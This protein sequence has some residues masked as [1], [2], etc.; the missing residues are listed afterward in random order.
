MSLQKLSDHETFVYLEAKNGEHFCSDS[1]AAPA[2]FH[3]KLLGILV[4]INL[5]GGFKYSSFSPRKIEENSHV[6]PYFSLG[7]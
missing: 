3:L 7:S 4:T 2:V 5:G 1:I 6:D